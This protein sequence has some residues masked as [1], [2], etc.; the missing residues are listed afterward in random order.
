MSKENIESKNLEKENQE[1]KDKIKQL[2]KENNQIKDQNSKLEK[3]N[4]ELKDKYS[5]LEKDKLQLK[6]QNSKL[7]KENKKIK[8][9]NIESTNKVSKLE[10]FIYALKEETPNLSFFDFTEYTVKSVIGKGSASNVKLVIKNEN[11][12]FA[13]KEL[14]DFSYKAVQRFI[15]ESEILFI[16]RHP[17]ILGIIATNMGDHDHPPSFI[18][19]LEPNS[20]ESAI[21]KKELENIQKCMITVEIVLGMRY[22]HSHNF[23]H[24]NLKPSNVLLKNL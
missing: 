14:K 16:L 23:M 6:D 7:E 11:D 13:M 18:L 9:E 4:N 22:I 20:L 21:E 12:K 1:L 5:K 8:K 3:E 17:C 2:E 10:S 15:G 19:S 24:R